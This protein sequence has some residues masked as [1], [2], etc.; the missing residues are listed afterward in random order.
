M[1]CL[2]MSNEKINPV[3]SVEKEL[4]RS[5]NSLTGTG[6]TNMEDALKAVLKGGDGDHS[7]TIV[8]DNSKKLSLEDPGN[9]DL[10]AAGLPNA[11]DDLDSN[12]LLLSKPVRLNKKSDVDNSSSPKLK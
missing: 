5:N 4:N 9:G 11:G 8:Y 1:E 6:G 3:N 7:F 12:E 2:Y 10:Y